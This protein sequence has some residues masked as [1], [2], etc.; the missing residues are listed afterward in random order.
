M[1]KVYLFDWGNTIMKDFP[2]ENGSMFMW[3]KVEA[4]PNAEELLSELSKHVDCYIA[5]NAKDSEKEDIRKALERVGLDK[6]FKDIFCFREIGFSKPSKEYYDYI[7]NKL[8]VPRS[9]ITMIGDDYHK[10]YL[11]ALQNGID[12]KLY[13]PE[14]MNTHNAANSL[15]DLM[16]IIDH[17]QLT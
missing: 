17:L 6:Y 14:N 3:S 13:N 15:S 12:A 5:T 8:K 10:D 7:V 9:G 2:D 11:G 4:M 1:K 16:A